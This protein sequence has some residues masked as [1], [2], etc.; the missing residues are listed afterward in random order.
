[1]KGASAKTP[2]EAAAPMP[3]TT[4]EQASSPERALTTES[5]TSSTALDHAARTHEYIKHLNFLT[6]QRA[7]YLIVAA[8]LLVAA[9]LG[10]GVKPGQNP[11]DFWHYW[12]FVITIAPIVLAALLAIVALLPRTFDEQSPLH[13][14]SIANMSIQEYIRRGKSISADEVL[15]GLLR[16]NHVVSRIVEHK[17]RLVTAAGRALFVGIT[18]GILMWTLSIGVEFIKPSFLLFVASSD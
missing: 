8:S 4:A 9:F 16:E 12:G 13:T 2:V 15:V 6:D 1:M 3:A 17:S 11:R 10:F 14:S 18:L 7:N 5:A